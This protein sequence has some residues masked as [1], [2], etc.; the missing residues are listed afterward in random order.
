MNVSVL[1]CGRWGTF[2][3]WYADKRGHDTVL[4]G[5]FASARLNRL[6]ETRCNDYL[7]LPESL[8]LSGDLK[9]TVE[10]ADFVII[11]I[12]SQQLRSLLRDIR[13]SGAPWQKPTYIL[14][15]KGIE[16]G[17]GKRLT[18]I[19][20]E[21]L[22]GATSAIWVGPG[23]VQ[24]FVAGVPNCM[25][26]DSADPAAQDAVIAAFGNDLIR[27]YYGAD[28][29]GNEIGAA[30]KNVVGIAAGM[31]D[32][33]G[34]TALKGALMARSPRE[35]ARLNEALGG[36][37]Q[38]AYGLAF[39]GD[40]EATLFSPNSHNRQFGEDW[41]RGIAFDKLAEGVATAEAIVAL[42]A[43]SG[44]ELPIC[45]CVHRILAERRDPRAELDGLFARPIKR[46]FA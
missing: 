20:S 8:A 6:A 21:E 40:F 1:G 13:A 39:L 25:V 10:R 16:T 46:E 7:K 4:W 37:A 3:A 32:G 36:D 9:G 27:F 41:V 29:I 12:S 24:S 30:A 11:S 19:V 23:H 28:L 44:V 15:M 42:G 38:S 14:C 18:E 22:P 17:T 45:A 34:L 33:L 2:L 31:L 35:I 26:V 43:R 5:R